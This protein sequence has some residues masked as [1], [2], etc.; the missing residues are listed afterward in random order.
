MREITTLHTLPLY[1]NRM[2]REMLPGM[3]K[4]LIWSVNIPLMVGD[5]I[6]L[7]T[8]LIGPNHLEPEKLVRQFYYRAYFNYSLLSEVLENMG[9]RAESIEMMWGIRP[10][11]DSK[12]AGLS[13]QSGAFRPNFRILRLIPHLLRFIWEKWHIAPVY[14]RR[15]PG[16]EA[17]MRE[18]DRQPV[19]SLTPRELIQ[20]IDRLYVLNQEIAYDNVVAQLLAYLYNAILSSQLKKFGIDA[21]SLDMHLDGLDFNRFDPNYHLELLHRTILNLDP[22]LQEKLKQSTFDD[23]TCEAGFRGFYEDTLNFMQTF[24]HLSDNGNDFSTKPWREDRN[25]ILQLVINYI[26]HADERSVSEKNKLYFDSLSI[27]WYH[28]PFIAPFYRRACQFKGFREHV[29][30][31]YTLGNSLFRVHFMALARQFTRNGLLKQPEDIF[32]LEFAEIRRLVAEGGDAAAIQEKIAMREREMERVRN[33][34]LPTI[35][36]GDQPPPVEEG[37]GQ[38]LSG[39]PTSCGYCQGRVKKVNG[40]GDFSKIQDGDILVI[41][42]SDVG[43]TPLFARAGGIIAESGG[44]LSHSSI[45]AR[46]YGI[47]A[48]VSVQGA[49]Q[50]ADGTLVAMDGYTGEIWIHSEHADDSNDE[51]EPKIACIERE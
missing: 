44:M 26:P 35:V 20:S 21:T 46:E 14:E 30:F 49:T 29:S 28:R 48:I 32:Y 1:S 22:A 24:G 16:L 37:I 17:A 23:I 47:P 19:D 43:W 18:I 45:V 40:L 3:L 51:G 5:K 2:S 10:E 13:R 27:P 38:K 36:Y 50:L 6:R 34:V 25:K 4:P 11:E 33:V 15:L 12:K 8:E 31:L 7:I 39:T 41:P 42:Y 9:F